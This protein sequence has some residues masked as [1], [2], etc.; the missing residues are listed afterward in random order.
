MLVSIIIPVHQLLHYFKE[1]VESALSQTHHDIEIIIACNGNLEISECKIFLNSKDDRLIFIK[2]AQ[3]RHIARNKALEIAKGDYIQ[4]LDYD[5][6]LY[7]TKIDVQLNSIKTGTEIAIVKWKKFSEDVS[8]YYKFP[9]EIIFEK[10]QIT[11]NELLFLL[12]KSNGFL[13]TISFLYPKKVL[14][15]ILWVD[16]PNDDAVF[17]SQVIQKNSTFILINQ[18]LS[19]YRVHSDNTS[20]KRSEAELDKLIFAWNQIEKNLKIFPGKVKNI[21]FYNAYLELFKLSATVSSKINL[22]LLKRSCGFALKSKNSIYK[23]IQIFKLF[24]NAF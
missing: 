23:L 13:A 2:T 9:F 17:F 12:G 1:C 15:D 7:K 4:F 10:Q 11:S 6:V 19:G 5:D 21:Y 8:E 16:A 20:S 22:Y 18:T 3:G 14:Q 24:C